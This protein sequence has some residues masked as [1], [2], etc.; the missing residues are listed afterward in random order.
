[1][2]AAAAAC[3]ALHGAGRRRLRQVH[4]QAQLVLG[5]GVVVEQVQVELEPGRHQG[6]DYGHH[7][8]DVHVHRHVGGFGRLPRAL[9]KAQQDLAEDAVEDVGRLVMDGTLIVVAVVILILIVILIVIIIVIL[10][11]TLVLTG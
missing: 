11:L 3:L 5:G 9:R 8:P 7:R 2:E 6:R 10:I 4:L 1:M